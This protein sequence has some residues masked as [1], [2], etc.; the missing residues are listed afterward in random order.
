MSYVPATPGSENAIRKFSDAGIEQAM[1]SVL[2][3]LPEKKNGA[4][5]MYADKDGIKGA[6]YGRRPGKFFGL[7]PAGEW[8]YVGTLGTTYKGQLDVGVAVAYSWP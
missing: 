3:N 6:V 8:S 5:V 7:L 1:R 4:V 2:G